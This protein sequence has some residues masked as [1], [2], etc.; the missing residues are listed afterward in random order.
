VK[1]LQRDLDM[2][3]PSDL[4]FNTFVALSNEEKVYS[5]IYIYLNYLVSIWC[6][7]VLVREIHWIHDKGY[8]GILYI[9]DIGK[10]EYDE[11]KDVERGLSDSRNYT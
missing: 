1:Q 7:V 6:V 10:V 2:T 11:T 9:Y 5:Y 8:N 4:D 3:I